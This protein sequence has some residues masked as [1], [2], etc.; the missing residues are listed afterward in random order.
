LDVAVDY[1]KIA[2]R[3]LITHKS[4]ELAGNWSTIALLFISK[5][6]FYLKQNGR[7]F[8]TAD[9]NG[10][11]FEDIRHLFEDIRHCVVLQPLSLSTVK[12]EVAAVAASEK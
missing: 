11:L 12:R 6:L 10:H 1:F 7:P 8:C 2:E 3:L 9:W 4:Y 5:Q